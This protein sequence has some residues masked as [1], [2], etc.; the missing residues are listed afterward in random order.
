MELPGSKKRGRPIWSVVKE[1]MQL[2]GVTE[3]DTE[4]GLTWKQ[5]TTCHRQREKLEEEEEIRE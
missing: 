2:V 3:E 1:D 5:M 4:D